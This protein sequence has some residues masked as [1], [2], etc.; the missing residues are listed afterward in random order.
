M[1]SNHDNNP[2]WH[3][4]LNELTT[5]NIHACK[6]LLPKLVKWFRAMGTDQLDDLTHLKLE[7]MVR[8]CGLSLSMNLTES[9]SKGVFIELAIGGILVLEAL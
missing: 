8:E 4:G 7:F 6:L 2:T 3:F 5:P 9:R 1:K